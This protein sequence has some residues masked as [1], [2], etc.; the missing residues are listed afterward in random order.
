MGATSSLY[1]FQSLVSLEG[2]FQLPFFFVAV[3]GLY[4]DKFFVRLPMAVYGSHVVTTV[5]PIL[6]ELALNPNY[7]DLDDRARCILLALYGPYFIIPL[8]IL[9]DSYRRVSFVLAPKIKSN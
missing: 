8:I 3:Y 9:V 2:L 4:H 6:T 5:A 7:A 1:W